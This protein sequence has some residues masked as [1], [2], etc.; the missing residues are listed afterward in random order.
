MIGLLLELDGGTG[1]GVGIISTAF[2]VI[3]LGTSSFNSKGI[4]CSRIAVLKNILMAV[5]RLRPSSLK[6]ASACSMTSL[7]V[8]IFKF[9]MH[10]HYNN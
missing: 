1:V 10:R 5:V 8:R 4:P 9:S 6:I 7:S 2:T 3:S